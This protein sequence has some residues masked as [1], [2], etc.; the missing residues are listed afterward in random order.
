MARKLNSCEERALTEAL[1]APESL[2][3]FETEPLIQ[4]MAQKRDTE[5]L[6]SPE[7]L[8]FFDREL[9]IIFRRR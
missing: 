8:D 7:L 1:L 4:S 3:S 2:D 6:L 9:P 5:L